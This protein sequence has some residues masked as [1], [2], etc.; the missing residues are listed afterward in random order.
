MYPAGVPGVS[1]ELVALTSGITVRVATSGPDDGPAVVLL[2]G[3]GA[4]LYMHRCA[5]EELA[6]AG[7]R[8]IAPDLRGHGLSDKPR[9]PG[10]YTTAAY[11]DDLF[12]LMDQLGVERASVV[13]QSMGA[14]IAVHAALRRPERVERIV[15]INPPN[16][17]WIP[18]PRLASMIGERV[19]DRVA[20]HVVPRWV[21]RLVLR[22]VAY[23]NPSLVTERDV[24][25]YWAPVQFPDY[26]RAAAALL[27]QFD[28]RPITESQLTE[29]APRTLII[30]GKRDRLIR[31]TL[32]AVSRVAGL[33]TVI[34]DGGHCV[35][36]ERAG[37]VCELIAGFV[38]E[39][40]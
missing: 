11:V 37:E 6:A 20:P 32:R 39:E 35:N 3:W 10:S 26:P 22:H 40:R 28:W 9:G 8:A 19:L 21:T 36:E 27:N 5:L 23:S 13:G 24:D 4:S 30:L 29:L 15:L 25:E 33:R 18:Y 2:H 1:V 14:A 31:G 7:F 16:L 34:L 38:G 17:V 12:A